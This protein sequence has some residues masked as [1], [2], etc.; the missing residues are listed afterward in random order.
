MNKLTVLLLKHFMY[1]MKDIDFDW[2]LLTDS[3]QEIFENEET[4][5]VVVREAKLQTKS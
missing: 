5:N 4:F 3:E 1:S 2:N